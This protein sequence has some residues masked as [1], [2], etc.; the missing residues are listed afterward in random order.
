MKEE[1]RR[2]MQLKIKDLERKMNEIQVKVH[3][4]N[5]AVKRELYE[6]NQVFYE[7]I[8]EDLVTKLQYFDS[9]PENTWDSRKKE[10]DG[11]YKELSEY[12]DKIYTEYT[13]SNDMGGLF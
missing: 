13:G 2:E 6:K 12:I 11:A 9:T 5:D 8:K 4:T 10:V 7:S 1:Y 3:S